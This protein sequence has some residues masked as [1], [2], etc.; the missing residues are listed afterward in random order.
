MFGLCHKCL[1]SFFCYVKE[2]YSYGGRKFG[3]LGLGNLGCVPAA[4]FQ[5]AITGNSS[6]GS[7]CNE[8]GSDYAR[9]H[10][11]KLIMALNKLHKEL[12]GFKYSYTSFYDLINDMMD[13]PSK[14]GKLIHI[15]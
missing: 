14:Y 4:R 7:S 15:K 3:I 13:H 10:N 2:I 12:Q 11:N 8:E 6:A 5:K 9:M 1:F